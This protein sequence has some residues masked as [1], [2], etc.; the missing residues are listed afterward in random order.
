MEIFEGHRALFRPLVRAAVTIGNF[1]GVHRGHQELLSRALQAA[2]RLGGDAVAMTFE[3]HPAAYLAPEKTLPRLTSVGRKQELFAE[4][5]MSATV[6]ETFD[7]SFAKLSAREFEEQVLHQSLGAEHVVVGHDFGYGRGREG[8]LDSLRAAGERL[9]FAVEIIEPVLVDGIRASSSEVRNALI[10]GDLPRA[11][12][13]L[14]RPYDVDGTVVRGA[15]RGR[16]FGIPTANVD[17]GDLLLPRPGIYATYVQVLGES[18]RYMAATSLGTNPT[19]VEGG[20]LTLEAH[21]LDFDGDLYD[22]TLR[23]S[24]LEWLRPEERYDDIDALLRQIHNDIQ[25]TRDILRN[26]A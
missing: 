25:D 24:F 6:V 5:G 22:N 7:A 26:K 20:A 13:L 10:A 23:V 15:G 11:Q 16:E 17:T 2:A 12:A 1:D 3:P 18:A 8:N 9:G 4:A 21:L 19:F 14:G